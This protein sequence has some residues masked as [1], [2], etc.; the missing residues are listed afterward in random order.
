MPEISP[1]KEAVNDCGGVVAVAVACGLSQR[2]IY[3]WISSSRL[4]RTEYTGETN[5]CDAIAKI[6][7]GKFTAQQLRESALKTKQAAQPRDKNNE[8][9]R[10]LHDS[11]L[12]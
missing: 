2:A 7:N 6:S 9:I 10:S 11:C 1:I 5:Y 4:P 3:K 8:P 12:P